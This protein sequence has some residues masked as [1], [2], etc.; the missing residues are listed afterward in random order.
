MLHRM[1]SKY[2]F[3]RPFC[4]ICGLTGG[5]YTQDGWITCEEHYSIPKP[6][7]PLY[8]SVTGDVIIRRDSTASQ[9]G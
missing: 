2:D 9:L 4:Q 8:D 6:A 5:W 1:K 3:K 7:L